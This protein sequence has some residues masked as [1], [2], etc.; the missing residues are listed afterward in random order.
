MLSKVNSIYQSCEKQNVHICSSI[1]ESGIL[2]GIQTNNMQVAI[3]S[4]NF[5]N[6]FNYDIIY[7][8]I[9]I[10]FSPDSMLKFIDI[11]EQLTKKKLDSRVLTLLE[12]ICNKK[13]YE[14]SCFIYKTCSY[15]ILEFQSNIN[16]SKVYYDKK[17]FEQVY[18]YIKEAEIN[19]DEM[20]KYI[21]KFIKNITCFDRVYYCEFQE[22][23]TGFIRCCLNNSNLNSLLNHHF[24][25]SDLPNSVKNLYKKNRYRL[26]SDIQNN[27][28][29]IFGLNKPLDLTQSFY[30]KI[31]S[32][33]IKYLH[34]MQV[35]SSTSFSVVVNNKLFALFGCHSVL[36]NY[37]EKVVLAKIHILIE[38]FSKRLEDNLN[39]KF[40][41]NIYKKNIY[42]QKFI[43]IYQDQNKNLNNIPKENF[44]L[45]KN[46]FQAN[47]IFFRSNKK[48][49]NDHEIPT[50]FKNLILSFLKNY[51]DKENI[52][53]INSLASINE[54]FR[55]FA[56]ELAA[57]M[58][59][60]KFDKN[61]S[62]LIIFLRPESLQQIRWCG[63]PND[64]DLQTDGLL[65][66]R[67]S[68]QTW[69]ESVEYSCKAWDNI[70]LKLAQNLYYEFLPKFYLYE[71]NIKKYLSMNTLKFL[72]KKNYINNILSFLKK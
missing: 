13:I 69:Y 6:I 15:I 70:D 35:R 25:A 50:E 53:L 31:G 61:F 29:E 1:Q 12:I 56:K 17:Y 47:H 14:L 36:P 32:T 27:N 45:L 23:E 71:K 46:T 39:Q 44:D 42:I 7:Q 57:G 65:N 66:P 26:I 60:L 28:I 52:I 62:N 20:I 4:N 54:E 22:D 18:L 33:H 68:F 9:N 64:L 34:N 38:L 21:C 58:L 24:P 48:W 16:L 51:K 8:P 67:N 55:K 3:Q 43:S 49:G 37:T 2:L 40:K 59:L 30:R 5:N 10:L 11:C 41:M 72:R 19:E 63:N